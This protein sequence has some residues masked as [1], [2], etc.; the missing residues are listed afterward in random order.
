VRVARASREHPDLRIGSSVRGAID[1]SLLASQL[2][3]IRSSSPL[4]E[5]VGLDA[6]LAALSGRIRLREGGSR[7]PEDIVRELWAAHPLESVEPAGDDPT[8]ADAAPPTSS[9]SPG[10]A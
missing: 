8:N 2:A 4:D 1:I 10:K 7:S 9:A 3:T 6:A 5:A